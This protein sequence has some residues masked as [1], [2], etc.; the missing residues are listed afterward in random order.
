[1]EMCEG[2]DRKPGA[3]VGMWWWDQEDINLTGTR[4]Q[5]AAEAEAEE[6]GVEE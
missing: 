2:T 4:D 1:M 6:D 3:R 5:A